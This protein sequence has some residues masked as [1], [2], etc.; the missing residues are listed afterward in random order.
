MPKD[1]TLAALSDLFEGV[2]IEETIGELSVGG[3]SVQAVKQKSKRTGKRDFM[4][5]NYKTSF[6]L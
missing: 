5:Q 4:K 3:L 6:K 2:E 1:S